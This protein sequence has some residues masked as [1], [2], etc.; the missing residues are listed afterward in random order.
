MKTEIRLRKNKPNRQFHAANLTFQ[1]HLQSRYSDPYHKRNGLYIF[2]GIGLTLV[3]L[4]A[5]LGVFLL[6]ASP[7][8]WGLIAGLVFIN[9]LF[10]FLMPAPTKKGA[11]V[12]SEIEGF[13]LY[14]ELSLIHI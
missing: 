8:F 1:R 2:I 6:P 11:K 12:K 7:I 10:L 13:K 4:M 5:V 3:G 14:L 9:L